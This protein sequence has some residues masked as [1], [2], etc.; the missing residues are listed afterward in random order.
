MANAKQ[1]DRC[2]EYYRLYN[3][4]NSVNNYNSLITANTDMFLKYYSHDIIELCPKCMES[5]KRWR[6]NETE[7]R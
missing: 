1:C 3:Y 4:T 5:F 2:K 6:L 7:S